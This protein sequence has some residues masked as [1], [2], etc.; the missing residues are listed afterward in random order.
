MFVMVENRIY[1]SDKTPIII[2]LTSLE[3]QLIKDM[4]SE[5]HV[6]ASFDSDVCNSE[7][8][9]ANMEVVKTCLS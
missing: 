1:D 8:I 3:K 4:R 7:D 6:F 5:D 9:K 2:G